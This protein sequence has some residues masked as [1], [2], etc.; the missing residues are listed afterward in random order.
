MAWL[1]SSPPTNLWQSG[2]MPERLADRLCLIHCHKRHI[3]Y[4]TERHCNTN[5]NTPRVGDTLGKPLVCGSSVGLKANIEMRHLLQFFIEKCVMLCVPFVYPA[6]QSLSYNQFFSWLSW[7]SLEALLW[8]HPAW[9][10]GSC[11]ASTKR[12][13][14]TMI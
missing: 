1:C 9:L 14:L 7:M 10:G 13:C 12:V 6:D 3:V 11:L 8:L 4:R 5:T 2:L